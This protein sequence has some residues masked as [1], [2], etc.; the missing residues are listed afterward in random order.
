FR[1]LEILISSLGRV[2]PKERLMNQLFNL[3]NDVSTN[4][5]ELYVSRLR[6][7]LGDAD[8]QITTARGV[9][10]KALNRHA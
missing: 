10:Y 7:K 9:G 8:L 5:L 1:L 6:R 3:D 2:V 4:A